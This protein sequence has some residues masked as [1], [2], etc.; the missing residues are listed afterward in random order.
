MF[1]IV[2]K[3]I[4]L[5]AIVH[6]IAGYH[7]IELRLPYYVMRVI[8]VTAEQKPRTGS[9]WNKE[10]GPFCSKEPVNN[11]DLQRRTAVPRSANGTN[12]RV[13]SPV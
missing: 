6:T 4:P 3:V 10:Q 11:N 2:D 1:L 12:S 13:F 5:V 9:I 7:K 8:G